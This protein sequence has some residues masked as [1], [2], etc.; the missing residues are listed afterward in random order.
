MFWCSKVCLIETVPLS[1]H[2]ICFGWEI[3]NLVTL[4]YIEA[5]G[6]HAWTHV[7]GWRINDQTRVCKGL[8]AGKACVSKLSVI[9]LAQ[10]L[11]FHVQLNWLKCWKIMHF[12]DLKFSDF[13][14]ILLTN[15]KM[16]T[17]V[18]ILTFMIR[19]HLM[20]SWAW[21][22]KKVFQPGELVDKH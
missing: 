7:Y 17:V 8:M 6:L 20:F 1:T 14:F 18:G 19:I 12:L 4:S 15:V 10:R 22:M 21:K 16:P 13:V 3:Q 11:Y 9:K 2:N 5:C